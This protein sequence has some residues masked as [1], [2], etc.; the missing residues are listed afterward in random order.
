MN[1]RPFAAKEAHEVEAFGPVRH[2]DAVY[3]L[4]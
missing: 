2:I 3:K 4:R 1:E